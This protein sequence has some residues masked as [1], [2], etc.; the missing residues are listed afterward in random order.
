MSKKRFLDV[1]GLTYEDVLLVPG[2]LD[3]KSRQEARLNTSIAGIQ[4]S[5][6]IIS[7]N[8]DTITEQAMAIN[9]AKA[10]GLGIFHRYADVS[11]VEKWGRDFLESGQLAK[12][13]VFSVG[14]RDL[15][16][17]SRVLEVA[18]DFGCQAI[19]VDVAHGHSTECASVVREAKRIGFSVIAGNVATREGALFLAEAGA[20]CI[21][22]GIGA[23]SRCTTRLVTGHGVPMVTSIMQAKE[24]L[25]EKFPNVAVIADGGLESSGDIVKALAAGADAVMTGKLLSGTD[26]CPS[27]GLSQYRGMASAEAQVDFLGKVSNNAAEGEAVHFSQTPKPTAKVLEALCGGIRSGMSYTGVKTIKELQTESR[28]IQ[29]TPSATKE[30]GTR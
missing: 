25:S 7:A 12:K 13:L 22:V 20:D 27:R 6:P 15:E 23:G 4:L 16:L 24:A 21:K 3:Y 17:T 10:G 2:L 14:T 29:V 18:S 5:I 19:C 28:F 11:T 9:M 30:N 1:T 8:M 26:W